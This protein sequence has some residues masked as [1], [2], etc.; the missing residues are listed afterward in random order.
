MD[1]LSIEKTNHQVRC[2]RQ[3]IDIRQ[4]YLARRESDGK[5]KMLFTRLPHSRMFIKSTSREKK[6]NNYIRFLSYLPEQ[7]DKRPCF[8]F[9]GRIQRIIVVERQRFFPWTKQWQRDNQPCSSSLFTLVRSFVRRSVD[10]LGLEPKSDLTCFFLCFLKH[11]P[12]NCRIFGDMNL[13]Q[14]ITKE[15][16]YIQQESEREGEEKPTWR[17]VIEL[18]SSLRVELLASSR[19]RRANI[20]KEIWSDTQSFGNS[21]AR[22]E[23]WSWWALWTD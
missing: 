18:S 12:A 20:G 13:H 6:G 1:L 4:F 17:R 8:D 16:A 23:R 9:F 2:W 15:F 22:S 10:S 3:S 7:Q 5:Q 21:I 11:L 14:S 19:R